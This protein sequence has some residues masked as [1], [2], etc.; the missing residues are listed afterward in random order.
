MATYNT[1]IMIT[2][3]TQQVPLRMTASAFIQNGRLAGC[4]VFKVG[5]KSG[6]SPPQVHVN[7]AATTLLSYCYAQIAIVLKLRVYPLYLFNI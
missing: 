5:I 2:E 1:L 7:Y 3:K 4:E 6:S